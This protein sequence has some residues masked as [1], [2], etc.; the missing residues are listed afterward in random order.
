MKVVTWNVNSVRAREE[1]LLNW[2]RANKPDVVCLQET[3]VPDGQF[4]VEKV[5]ELGYE[6]ALNGQKA[7]NGVALLSRTPIDDVRVGFSDGHDDPQARFISGIVQGTRVASVYIP[8]GSEVGSDKWAYKLAW[9]KRL[10]AYL[11]KHHAE[12]EPLLVCGDY[13]VALEARDV[14]RPA[15]WETSVLFHP[16]ARAALEHFMSFGLVDVFRKLREEPGL[17]SW[18]DYRMLGFPKGNGLRIDLVLGTKV[19]ADKCVEAV[20]DR[21]ERKGKQPS[22]HAPVALTFAL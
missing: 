9:L 15:E 13:N 17:Y 4:P 2:L 10:R 7:Y 16:E 21:N 5:R 18:W 8:N 14:A 1:R 12:G 20:I 3:K 22:D 19:I 6:V 11:E